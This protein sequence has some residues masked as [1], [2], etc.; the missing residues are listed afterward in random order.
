MNSK[1]IARVI[2]SIIAL[3]MVLSTLLTMSSLSVKGTE[4]TDY[5]GLFDGEIQTNTESL[6]DSSVVHKLPDTVSDTDIISLIIKTD[7]P[8]VMDAYKEADTDLSLSEFANSEAAGSVKQEI[9]AKQASLLADLDAAG[10]DY[11]LGIEY[12]TVLSG[13]EITVKAGDL[14]KVDELLEGKATPIVGEVYLPAETQLV[15]NTVDVYET[16]IFDSSNF[17]YDG[18]GMVVAVLDTGLDYYHTA[19]SVNNFTADRSKL[20]MTFA[21]VEAL[22]GKTEAAGI[23]SGLTASDVYISEKVPYSFDYADRDSDVYPIQSDHGTH[24]SGIITGRDDTITGVAPNSQLVAM[25]IFS[26][27][28]TQARTSWILGALEDCVVL[29]VD[30]INLSIGTSCGFSTENE[31]EQIAGVYDHIREAGISL[32]VA[33]SNSYNS[34]YGSEKNGNLGLTSNPDSATVGS[35]STYAG[36]LCVASI[37]GAKTPYMMY[38]GKIIYFTDSADRAGEAKELIKDILPEGTDSLELEFV[39]IPGAGRSADYT[40]IDVTGKV[41]LVARG[42]TTFEEKVNVAQQK[43]AAA[44][45]VYNNV[46]GEIRMN[47]GDATIPSCSISQDDGEMLEAAGKG[48]ITFSRAQTSGPFMSGFSSWGPTPDLE[49][50]PE[51]TAHGGSILSAVPGQDYDRISGTSMA[52]P[53]MSGVVALLRQ[54]VKENLSHLATNDVEVA[55]LVNRLLMS[56]ADVVLGKNGLPYSVR[57]QGAGLANLDECALTTAYLQTYDRLDGSIMDKS[58]I[59]LGDDP[60]KEGVYV[61]KFSIVNFGSTA[62][63][64]N[65]SAIV[66]TEGVS[67]TKTVDGNTVVTEE[68]YL[69]E[70][71]DVVVTAVSGGTQDGQTVTVGAGTTADV[72]LTV[73]LS[74]ADKQYL[75]DSFENGMYVEGFVQ[76]DAQGE[77]TVD[78]G[79]PFL[80]FYGDWTRAPMFDIEY[81]ET[82]KDELDDAIDFEDKTMPDAYA[83]RPIGSLYG[84]YISYLGSF[85]FIQDPAS[86]KISANRDYIS[87]SNQEGA[88]NSLE[89]VWL[90][91]LRGAKEINITIT[92]DSTGEVVFERTE[93][94]IRKSYSDG[95]PSIYP[96]NLDVGFSA[97]E[98]NLKNNTKYTVTIKGLLDYG[99]GG[100]DTNLRNTMTF[101][102]YTDFEAPAVTNTEFYTE[103]DK[104]EKI[105]RLYAKVS[106]YDNHYAMGMQ[107]GYV[108]LKESGYIFKSFGKYVTAIYSE[109]N[110]TTEVIIELTDYIDDIKS[111]AAHKNTFALTCYD[112][113]MNEATYEIGLPDE[114]VDFYLPEFANF[115][116][117]EEQDMPT[118]TLSPNQTYELNPV[119]YPDD[120]WTDLLDYVTFNPDNVAVVGNTLVA[121]TPGTLT[122][123]RITDPYDN[124]NFYEFRVKVLAEGDVGYVQYDKPV[125]DYF[126]LTGYY[127]DKAFHFVNSSDRTLGSTG[128]EAKFG[129]TN[130]ALEMY[131]SE[132]VTVRYKL[133]AYFPAD[134]KV[135]FESSNPDI[136]TVD[137]KTG[138]IVAQ[139][140]GFAS[141]SATVMMDG[142]STYYSKSISIEVKDP[143][144]TSGPVL[145]NYFGLGGTVVIPESLSLTEIGQFAF[146]N[147]D[148]IDKLPE[149][150]TEE[151]PESSK[152]WY[153]GDDTIKEVVIPEGVETISSYA[154]ANLTALERVVLPSTLTRID[155]GAFYGC[156][157]LKNVVGL[158]NVKF[159]NESAFEGCALTGTLK[160]DSAVA[161]A[162]YAFAG[163]R[164]L[165]SVTLSE[166]I[167]SI[168]MHAFANNSSLRT[169]TIK[170]PIYKIGQYAFAGCESLT[171]VSLN[172][173]VIPTGAFQGAKNLQ[174]VTLG[175]DVAVINENAFGG[176]KLSSITIDKDNSRFVTGE[177]LSYVVDKTSSTLILVA[178]ATKGEFA[179]DLNV[180]TIGTGAFS[181][182]ANITSVVLP[183]VTQLSP[184]AFADCTKLKSVTLGDLAQIGDY[185]FANTGLTTA[186]S[187]DHLDY[188]GA[189][190]FSGSALTSVTLPDGIT[191]G[192]GA[193]AECKKLASVTVGNNVVLGNRAFCLSS[194]N[195]M[196]IEAETLPNDVFTTIYHVAFESPL[197]SLTIGDG[198][199]IG[200][201]AFYGAVKLQSVTL[202][203]GVTIGD[204]AFYNAA[205]LSDI[206]LSRVT[207][208]GSYAF[209][210]E[211]YNDYYDDTFTSPVVDANGEYVYRYFAPSLTFVS[212]D[213]VTSLGTEAFAYCQL[214][215]KVKLGNGVTTIPDKTFLYCRSLCQINLDKVTEIGSNTFYTTALKSLTLGSIKTLGTYAFAY[216]DQLTDVTFGAS[217]VT[218]SEGAFAYDTALASVSGMQNVCYVGDYAFAYSILPGADL[219]NATY[220]GTHAFYKENAADF[221][222]KL[223]SALKELGD[224]PFAMCR[225]EKFSTV[226]TTSFNGKEYPTVV[227]TFDISDTVHVID[228]HLYRTVPKGLEM[229]TYTGD[230]TKVQVADD[231]VR[232]SAMAFAGTPVKQVILPYTLRALGHKAFFGCD[233]LR[234]VTFSSYNAPILEEEFDALYHESYDNIPA[235]GDYTFY[236]ADGSTLTKPGL[237]IIQYYMWNAD[238]NYYNTYYG[239]SFMDYVGHVDSPITMVRPINGNH[240]DSFIFAQYFDT[241]VD[242]S[243]AADD[244]TLA[245]IAAI[246]AIPEKV[247]LEHKHLVEAARAA[248]DKIS[249]TEQKALVTNLEKLTA[250]ERR[251]ADLEALAGEDSTAPEQPQT[252]K[253]VPVT[254]VLSIA[255]GIVGTLS[256]ILAILC[257]I[258]AHK[259]FT[260][261]YVAE[262]KAAAKKRKVAKAKLSEKPV[263]LNKPHKP[264]SF[265]KPGQQS[266]LAKL[267]SAVPLG[268]IFTIIAI[269]SICAAVVL[270]M[271]TLFSSAGSQWKDPYKQLDKEGYSVSV[272]FDAG[273]GQFAG[274]DVTVVDI[275]ALDDYTVDEDGNVQISLL[276]PQ[277]KKRGAQAYVV[278]YAGHVLAGWYTD[279]QPRVDEQGRPLDEYGELTEISGR[280]QGWIYSG[281]WDFDTDTLRVDP[282][283]VDS[284]AD[285]VLTLYAAW[286]PG[287]QFNLYNLNQLDQSGAPVL[288][289]TYTNSKLSVPA[290][291]NGAVSLGG[292]FPKLDGTPNAI[293]A[294]K[295]MTQPI[296]EPVRLDINYENGTSNTPAMDVYVDLWEGAWFKISSAKQLYK[297]A[298]ADG[299]YIIEAD[300]DFSVKGAIWPTNFYK[301]QN[302]FTGQII[303]NGHKMSNITVVQPNGA[304]QGGLFGFI[305]AGASITD[306]TFENVTYTAIGSRLQ[307]ST[308]G[309]LAGT[310]S[311]QATLENVTVSGKLLIDPS[312][313][314]DDVDV[315]TYGLI[316]G[317]GNTAGISAENVSVEATGDNKTRVI[318]TFN[319]ETGEVIITK[320]EQN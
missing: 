319:P 189:Y 79:C 54:Y 2:T 165:G 233:E 237:G 163:N 272:R 87:L 67:E 168:G 90:G 68:G 215:E 208:I 191:T 186:P 77:G 216:C 6:F 209:S 265:G 85:Y 30:V 174:K 76:L 136:V 149:E 158:E 176:T 56:T 133:N 300:L 205:S 103:Y 282:A 104:S 120:S 150:I 309:L 291:N 295:E 105:N 122:R 59:E 247:T 57:K 183:S 126:D 143:Y 162:D 269:G 181:G 14:A 267:L 89:Y 107:A 312:L 123:I 273:E 277:D 249:T 134:T 121:V 184:Y 113:A 292:A 49:I 28:D 12:N 22:V 4:K 8:S 151:D 234:L 222:V 257:A 192:T 27:T 25:K 232:I 31:K 92:E 20:G 1:T 172:T 175:K 202:G 167:Q 206:D 38:D 141:I 255:L 242:G 161:I 285:E 226:E 63:T 53:N 225:L 239:A 61:L 207:S 228:G 199:Q 241:F 307:G 75:N 66:M 46:S 220:I 36:A 297:H 314:L 310:I 155:W 145:Q 16:G 298:R 210:G 99:D 98:Q 21:D 154:F 97:I 73:T 70:G 45:I 217:E 166:S 160:L 106:I 218:V 62:L 102:L 164:S 171:E 224:N 23:Q 250:A 130:Y 13:F 37:E 271:V 32:V 313:F 252:P 262:C 244:I 125:T 276:D 306:L 142:K 86:K 33:A 264:I 48:T 58:K 101:P 152:I 248:Y 294:D 212:L 179:P 243:A 238:T 118:L 148:Y 43:G 47:V 88:I 52:T 316:A 219:S 236:A 263:K 270:M 51:I 240:Y 279:R 261:E 78:L 3:L 29:G 211:V 109:Y 195:N 213:S 296:T 259:V 290:W 116:P 235:T 131:P 305:G 112:Y 117:S 147:Y 95:G 132:S 80:A 74:D 288:L 302:Q 115:V 119:L 177:N 303:G 173:A 287:I 193:F 198:V 42:S 157:S 320:R 182:N 60:A 82:N 317:A 50:K 83:S 93:E 40:G 169:L 246:D 55:A 185:A 308:I 180:T 260:P 114:Y 110:S 203:D 274:R 223:G 280:E 201:R 153:I 69:L 289:Q 227:Y 18:T 7:L 10:L 44:V 139:K 286:V 230:D 24:V 26:D 65:V 293:Y 11:E 194:Y 197:T 9:A 266:K 71:A 34:T 278:D 170:A 256:L 188:I 196:K 301:G 318:L 39:V 15:E 64:Y 284:G 72:E 5:I 41:A 140:E 245:A 129:S 19:F 254:L 253:G 159:I 138:T 214:L 204:Y 91:M 311:D 229:I 221:T 268:K 200:D 128:D 231:T 35:P 146:S 251:I 258:L 315:A 17:A 299:N 283:S 187:F 144:V 137:E 81:F 96:A 135:V 281:R 100:A 127:V 84:D 178:P 156:T 275:F 190:A 124:K 304:Q 94:Y 111:G 108:G